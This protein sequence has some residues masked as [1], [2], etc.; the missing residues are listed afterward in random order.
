MQ[1]QRPF[2]CRECLVYTKGQT[3]DAVVNALYT[4]R[5]RRAV[6]SFHIGGDGGIHSRHV[7]NAKVREVLSQAVVRLEERRTRAVA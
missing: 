2:H 1:I 7:E 5:D 3:G 6:L 4:Q